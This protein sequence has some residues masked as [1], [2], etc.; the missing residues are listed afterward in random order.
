M[1][2][3]K[4]LPD[5]AKLDYLTIPE[6]DKVPKYMKGTYAIYSKLA[7]LSQCGLIHNFY[8]LGRLSY[9]G[10]SSAIDEFNKALE[11]KYNFYLK[12]FQA[13]A[14]IKDKNTYTVRLKVFICL[15]SH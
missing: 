14:S 3:K 2:P 10:V 5:S 12:G 9:E 15:S 4:S 8:W 13:M 11:T 6:F 7:W 1:K